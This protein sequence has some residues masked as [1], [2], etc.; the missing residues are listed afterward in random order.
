MVFGKQLPVEDRVDVVGVLL[1]GMLL[2]GWQARVLSAPRM[3]GSGM[4]EWDFRARHQLLAWNVERK[5]DISPSGSCM[6][7][8]WQSCNLTILYRAQTS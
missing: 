1:C 3:R 6:S 7:S 4:L 5:S 2:A 8:C